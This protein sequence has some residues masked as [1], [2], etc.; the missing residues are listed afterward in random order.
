MLIL[1][2]LL[3]SAFVFAFRSMQTR[4]RDAPSGMPRNPL[5]AQLAVEHSHRQLLALLHTHTL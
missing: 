5:R 3:D 2:R 4:R 1:P